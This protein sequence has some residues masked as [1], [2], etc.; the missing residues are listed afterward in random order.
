MRRSLGLDSQRLLNSLAPS[1]GMQSPGN[2]ANV[3]LCLLWDKMGKKEEPAS[4]QAYKPT[5]IPHV[6]NREAY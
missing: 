1:A 2:N 4:M 3:T 5:Y 6:T